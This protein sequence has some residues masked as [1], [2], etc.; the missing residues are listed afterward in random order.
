MI[1]VN[2]SAYR[3]TPE[4]EAATVLG[5]VAVLPSYEEEASTPSYCYKGNLD[6]ALQDEVQFSGI[7]GEPSENLGRGNY[8]I[9]LNGRHAINGGGFFTQV[10]LYIGLRLSED[11]WLEFHIGLEK[12]TVSSSEA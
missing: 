1:A 5:R 7:F 6:G 8:S 10:P 12:K 3:V 9:F 2:L 11:T 4:E